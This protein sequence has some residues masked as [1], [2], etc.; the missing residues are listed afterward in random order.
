[1]KLFDAHCHLQDNT[2]PNRPGALLTEAAEKGVACCACCGTAEADWSKVL[3]LAAEHSEIYPMIGIHPWLVIPD[4][5]KSFQ[6]LRDLLITNPSAGIGETGLDFQKRFANRAEQEASFIAHLDLADELGRPVAVHCVRAWGRLIEILKEHP[7]PRVLLHAF[8]GPAEL[9]PELIKLNCWFSVGCTVT[10]PD[11]KRVREA[12][13]Q[14][15][16]DRLLVE[17]DSPDLP[18]RGI[19]SPNVP[20]NLPYV[21]QALSGIRNTSE[22]ALSTQTFENTM[23]FF[24]LFD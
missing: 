2:L 4:W 7:A 10:N 6:K 17:T 5:K 3:E 12:A 1:M 16:I 23:R 14:I 22:E 8:G 15:P 19:D 21:I 11:A 24:Q 20:A 9:I 13:E 18:P